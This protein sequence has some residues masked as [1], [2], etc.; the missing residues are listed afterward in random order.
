MFADIGF[1][2]KKTTGHTERTGR[3]LEFVTVYTPDLIALGSLFVPR[4]PRAS[5]GSLEH[6]FS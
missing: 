4:E 3:R 6:S 1:K 5:C 2:K